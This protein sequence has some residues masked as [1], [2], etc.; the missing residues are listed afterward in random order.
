MSS[1]ASREL[2]N[3]TADV[4]RRVASGERVT[5]TVRGEPVAEIRPAADRRREF[6]PR[7]ELLGLLER[8]QADPGLREDLA[9][10]AGDTTADL[11]PIGW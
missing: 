4:L 5:I 3:H 9:G 1:V 2:R 8:R 7:G 11:G 10:L 6:V